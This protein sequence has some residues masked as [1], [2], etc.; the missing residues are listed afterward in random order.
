MKAMLDDSVRPIQVRLD[1]DDVNFDEA[2]RV[3]EWLTNTFYVPLDAHRAL[4]AA[5]RARTA[6]QVHA[7]GTGDGLPVR[8]ER[9]RHD[10]GGEPGQERVSMRSRSTFLGERTITL[11]APAATLDAFNATMQSLLAGRSQVLLDVR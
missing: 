1:L 5:T 2:A 3:L 8:A 6:Q 10:R 11:R 7:P 9:R 4:V